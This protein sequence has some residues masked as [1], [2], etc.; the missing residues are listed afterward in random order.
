MIKRTT[1]KTKS[2]TQPKTRQQKAAYAP[3]ATTA[4]AYARKKR[5]KLFNIKSLP[6]W[7]KK[8]IC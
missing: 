7:Y 8:Q 5:G 3:T 4:S 1:E 6:L 2:C